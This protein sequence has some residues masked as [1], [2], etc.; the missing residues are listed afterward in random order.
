[1]AEVAARAAA[2]GAAPSPMAEFASCGIAVDEVGA[3]ADPRAVAC[4]ATAGL[5]LR[6]HTTRQADAAM[7]AAAD[8]IYAL[9]QSVLAHLRERASADVAPRIAL[10]TS[11]IPDAGV[12]DIDDPYRGTAADYEAAFALIR[13]AADALAQSLPSA[14]RATRLT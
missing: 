12:I 7:L 14:P 10:L 3:G 4:V 11:L 2:A 13:R 8:R 1:M 5:D 6:S 9:D